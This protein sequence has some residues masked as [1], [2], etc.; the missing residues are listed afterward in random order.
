ME[1]MMSPKCAILVLGLGLLSACATSPKGW[2][3]S[4]AA[5]S[6]QETDLAQCRYEAK[7]ATASFHTEPSKKG[8]A[9]AMGNAVGD[10]I[11]KA[12]KQVE[13]TND[14]MKARGYA[15]R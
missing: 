4:G 14:C 10:G 1:V 13:L 5:R 7:A 6:Q 2:E 9:A 8:E 15:P 11:V 12:E 3:K